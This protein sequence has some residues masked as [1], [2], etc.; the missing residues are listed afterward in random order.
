L[1][2]STVLQGLGFKTAVRAPTETF[3]RLADA[4]R[5]EAAARKPNCCCWMSR[6]IT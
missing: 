3:R 4:D 5:V 1:K 6:R 2:T